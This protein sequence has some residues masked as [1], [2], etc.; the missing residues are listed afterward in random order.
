MEE[1][2]VGVE[3]SLMSYPY[4]EEVEVGEVEHQNHQ[5]GEGEGVELLVPSGR[6]VGQGEEE[7]PQLVDD[8]YKCSNKNESR[9][10][11]YTNYQ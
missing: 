10:N 6:W 7:D 2:V 3:P 1:E 9:Y 4:L 11:V 8:L 5:L